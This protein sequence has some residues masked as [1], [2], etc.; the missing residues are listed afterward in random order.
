M[1][2]EDLH[3]AKMSIKSFMEKQMQTDDLVAVIS[4]GS[5]AGAIDFFSSDKRQI[6]ARVDGIPFSTP[7]E[8]EVYP[9]QD[10][11]NSD[12]KSA[13]VVYAAKRLEAAA[14]KMNEDVKAR[15][16]GNQ[17]ST[18]SYSLRAL[19]DMPGRKIL[20]FMSSMPAIALNPPEVIDI[21]GI[22]ADSGGLS[23]ETETQSY[24]FGNPSEN[25][26][27]KYVNLLDRLADEALRSGVVVHTLDT[28]GQVAP[29]MP[30]RLVAP[31]ANTRIP[32][33]YYSS[34]FNGLSDKTGGVFVQNSNF[35]LDGVG[36]EA[37]SMISGYYLLSYAPPSSTFD[38]SRKNFY[39]RV[40]VKVKRKGAV[41]YT[42]DGFYGRAESETDSAALP[43][44]LH[45]A[46][47]SPFKDT[48]LDV[49]MSA[50]YIKDAKA[51][52]LV[53][54]W[55]HLDPNGV[56]IVETEDGGARVDL[57]AMCM[58]SDITGYVHDYN[59]VRYTFDIKPEKK[60]ENLDWLQKHG[61]RF[62]LLLPVK[63]PGAYTVRIAVQ[64][65]E[66][67]KIG[68]AWQPIEIP[69]LKKKG[70]ALSDVFMITGAD[71]LYWMLSD[72]TEELSKSMFSLTFQ[73]GEALSPALRSYMYGDR[74]QTLAV[75]YNADAKAIAA[76][77][78]AMQSVLYKD[79]VEYRRGEPLP[80]AAE[81]AGSP[82]GVLVLRRFMVGSDM[83]P[84]E[85][86]LQM[87]AVDRKNSKKKE[88]V[89]A[90]ALYFT[91]AE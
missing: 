67:G 66:S 14:K 41:V 33:P 3:R 8:V 78:I 75:L 20:F 91:V 89:A 49:N 38:V 51:G 27:E 35:F 73:A 57:E 71:D 29:D 2:A 58:T 6:S 52:Y 55:I 17:V 18:V 54:S 15:I 22:D 47:F 13:H 68:S 56:K 40:D 63:K 25:S 85:Y 53:R 87:V 46:I 86:V 80:L 42:R 43:H 79:G 81:S 12:G 19:K 77:D 5:G 64:D 65:K 48:G 62:S 31:G 4:T 32:D 16:H 44:S 36:R 37:N 90:Q 30:S 24:Y 88:G 60:S 28:R 7:M 50:G 82:D 76:S 9:V 69:D 39:H 72:A 59:H 21:E 23:G 74:F 1:K 34:G 26:S 61:I 45:G 84:G 83:P 11:E 10:D 70:L